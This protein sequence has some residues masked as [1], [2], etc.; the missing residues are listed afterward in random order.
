M[1]TQR[2]VGKKDMNTRPTNPAVWPLPYTCAQPYHLGHM[3][4]G[5]LERHFYLF[6]FADLPKVVS[7]IFCF[8]QILDRSAVDIIAEKVKNCKIEI[9]DNCGHAIIFERPFRSAK[10]I[11]QFIHSLPSHGS[12]WIDRP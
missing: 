4:Q 12:N 3:W 8:L 5:L 1:R 2:H 10:L 9:V 6:T 11:L 7:F